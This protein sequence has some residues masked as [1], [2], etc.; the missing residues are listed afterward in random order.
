MAP[1]ENITRIA[2]SN[3][4]FIMRLW[5]SMGSLGLTNPMPYFVDDWWEKKR[6][7]KCDEN[8]FFTFAQHQFYKSKIMLN[9]TLGTS[10]SKLY[11]C[12]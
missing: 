4:K 6:K 12:A 8:V 10:T 7:H 2:R 3:K 11:G 9:P 1:C 5:S